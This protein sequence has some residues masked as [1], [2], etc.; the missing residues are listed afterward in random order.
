MIPY[1]PALILWG[2]AEVVVIGEHSCS[3][4]L[5]FSAQATVR[6]FAASRRASE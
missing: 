5:Q 4:E 1:Q 2:I 3:L 6:P